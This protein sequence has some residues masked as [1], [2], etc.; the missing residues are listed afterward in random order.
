MSDVLTI[1]DLET[2]KKHD[3]FHS[4]VITGKAGGLASGAEI[5]TA[6]NAVTGQV[7]TTLPKV[8]RDVGFKP[9]SFTFV[10]GG[11]L[12][13]ADADK[14]IYNPAPAGDN[15]WYSWSGALPHTVAPGTDPTAVG[16]GYVSRTDVVLRSQLAQPN[17]FAIVGG[18]ASDSE[19][20][21]AIA[22]LDAVYPQR[23]C[24]EIAKRLAYGEAITLACFGDSTMYGYLVGGAT[25]QVQDP[26]NPPAALAETLT[27]L[28]LCAS[29]INAA[30]SGSNLE[31]ML[32][33]GDNV[34]GFTYEQ[35][36]APGGVAAAAHVVYCNHGINNCQSNLSIDTYRTDLIRFIQITRQY[37]KIPVLVTPTPLNVFECGDGVESTQILNYV[38]VMREVAAACNCDIVDNY[39]YTKSTAKKITETVLIPD[40][41]HPSGDLYYQCGRNLAMP[42]LS[43]ITL[44]CAGD[45]AGINGT[46]WYSNMSAPVSQRD[47]TRTGFSMIGTRASSETSTYI[48]VIFD[49]PTDYLSFM[50]L[51][52]PDGATFNGGIAGSP[53]PAVVAKSGKSYGSLLQYKWDTEFP[54]EINAMAGLN[55]VYFSFD[56]SDSRPANKTLAFSGLLVPSQECRN[57]IV[58][59]TASPDFIKRFSFGINERISVS[60]KFAPGA[61]DVPTFVDSSGA[62]AAKLRLAANGDMYLDLYADGSVVT[63][64]LVTGGITT[65]RTLGVEIAINAD[66]IKF[67]ACENGATVTCTVATSNTMPPLCMS[68][69]GCA[70][71][72]SYQ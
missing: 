50:A 37:G 31:I 12:G 1:T 62:V 66:S 65:E 38:N 40:G 33:G 2:A 27:T 45:I 51:Q 22:Q 47:E 15:N 55:V 29:V 63:S 18:A 61:T 69:V 34:D 24:D 8:L 14:C 23:R 68:N 20:Q 58:P 53:T 72:I 59:I 49:E 67:S 70:F 54:C 36:I 39:R 56:M 64:T 19:L 4:E 44:K 60:Y 71:S 43:T 41:I 16:S 42:L 10:T 5:D 21:T 48:P 9:A 6:T 11:T 30:I 46:S 35:R 28:A 32:S 13:V 7:Q 3:T 17:G 57:G 52:W 26:K 25:P